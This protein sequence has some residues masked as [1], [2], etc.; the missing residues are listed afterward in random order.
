MDVHLLL[1]FR[2][3]MLGLDASG[4]RPRKAV[5]GLD[6]KEFPILY[7]SLK[8]VFQSQ[9]HHSHNATH[10]LATR[11]TRLWGYGVYHAYMWE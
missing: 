1:L 3:F 11:P 9:K 2:L 7:E 5:A 8:G 6:L 10:F 4:I